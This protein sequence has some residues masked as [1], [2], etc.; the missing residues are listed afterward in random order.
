MSARQAVTKRVRFEVFK[1]DKFTCQYCGNKA[2]DVVLDCDHIRPVADGGPSDVL[3]LVTS[4][5][6]CNRGKGAR[7]LDDQAVLARQRSQIEDLQVRREQLEMMLDW[8]DAEE[9]EKIDLVQA[10]S[11]RI[12]VR[13]GGIEPNES[14]RA[15]IRKWLKR[16]PLP[17][18]LTALDQA[19][20]HYLKWTEDTLDT[21][22]WEKMFAKIPSF[23][24]LNVAAIDDPHMPRLAY[25]QGI[26][27]NRF[28]TPRFDYITPLND[29]SQGGSLVV[30]LEYIAKRADDWGFFV[31]CAE[32]LGEAEAAR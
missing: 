2:P 18:L 14:G 8:R 4:C 22:S 19:C 3:N 13:S 7:T 23:A 24:G 10:V 21:D 20:D 9:A 16:F 11:D 27:R 30:G 28:R 5:F 31:E 15:S 25:I 12:S 17:E 32:R 6:G 26:L 29:L 1:R